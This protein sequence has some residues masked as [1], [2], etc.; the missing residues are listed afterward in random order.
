M[1]HGTIEDRNLRLGALLTAASAVAYSTAGFFTRLIPLD[2]WTI[3]FW[4]GVFGG[5]FLAAWIVWQ[6]RKATLEA[7]RAIGTLGLACA[8]CSTL[9]TICYINALQRTSVADVTVIFATA[10]FAT[11]ALAWLWTGERQSRGTLLAS[12]VALLG[13]ALTVEAARSEGRLLGDVLA[14]GMT[15]LMAMMMVIVRATRA[16]SM[17]PAACLSAF[18]LAV[19]VAPLAHTTL[20]ADINALYLVLFGTTQ[21]GLGLLLLTTGTRLISAT[22]SA[23]INNLEVPLAPAWVWLAFGETLSPA[24]WGGG[25]LIV[26]AI[27]GDLLLRRQPLRERAAYSG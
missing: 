22:L 13:V 18:G 14:L 15:L 21:F 11:A 16:R 12:L 20:P 17:L 2:A 27:L 4:R 6:E 3:L 23:L 25:A 26:A 24:V 9:A 10:P 8:A 5:L 19:I 7:F 1:G